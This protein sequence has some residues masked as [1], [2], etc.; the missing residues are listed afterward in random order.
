[1]YVSH[2]RIMGMLQVGKVIHWEMCKKLK[3][4][5][6]KKWYMHNLAAVLVNDTHKFL[7]D[8]DI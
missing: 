3:F 7:W 6:T 1:M 8:V 2:I 5:H 4:D